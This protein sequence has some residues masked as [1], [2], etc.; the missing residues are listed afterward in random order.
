MATNFDV[1]VLGSGLAGTAAALAA[2]RNGARVCVVTGPP[3]TTAMFSGAWCGPIPDTFRAA[4]DDTGYRLTDVAHALPHPNGRLLE[5]SAAAPSHAGA[6]THDAL[7][8]GIAGLPGFNASILARQW[9]ARASARLL[10]DGTPPAGWAPASLAT[11][12]RADAQPFIAALRPIIKEH[13]AGRVIVPAILGTAHDGALHAHV[14]D[15][16]G[17]TIAE[18]LGVPPSLPGWRLQSALRQLLTNAGVPTFEQKAR[19]SSRS[20]GRVENVTLEDGEVVGAGAYVLTTGK[21]A[22]GGIDAAGTFREPAFD[23]PVWIDHLGDAFDEA[24]PLILTDQDRT[25]NQELLLAGV[26]ADARHRPVDRS[27]DVV[28]TNVYIAGTIRAGWSAGDHRAGD[29]AQDGWNAGLEA[30]SA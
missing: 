22:S 12:I 3:G 26:H 9:Q 4:L 15:A 6:H 23:C 7:V 24:E 5:C 14:Q 1:A 21:Y 16:L 27:G 2:A 19:T 29:A 20:P 11:H 18:A 13:A 28:Y 8:V 17:V 25:E 10:L 30:V